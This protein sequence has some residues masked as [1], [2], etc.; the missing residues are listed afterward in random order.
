M[1]LLEVKNLNAFYGNS[2]VLFNLSLNISKNKIIAL[3]GRNGAGKSSTFKAITGIIKVKSGSI[4]LEGKEL[5]GNSIN[6]RA[7]VG[8]G[9]VPEDRQVFPEHSVEEN[10]NLGRKNNLQNINNWQLEKIWDTFPLLKNLRKR[11]AGQLSGGEQ[12]MLS[13]ARTL[14]G[15]PEVLLLDEPSEGLAPIIVEE[16]EKLLEKLKKFGVTILIAEQNMNFCMKVA[17]EAIIIDKGQS[18]WEGSIKDLNKDKKTRDKYLA[19]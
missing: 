9:Y 16:I 19:I 1:P 15:N 5:V 18:V 4:K 12:Q 3:L 17:K 10:I 8:I 2:Q 14:A 11:L 6:S 7:K 13:I